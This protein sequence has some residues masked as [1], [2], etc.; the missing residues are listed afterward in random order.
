MSDAF[1]S[2]NRSAPSDSRTSLSLLGRVRAGESQAWQRLVALYRPLVHH[3][4]RR[5]GVI[6]DDAEDIVQ[7]VFAT[8]AARIDTFRHDRPGDTFRGWLCGIHRNK[9]LA[10]HRRRGQQPQASGGSA[11]FHLLE[12]VPD[13]AEESPSDVS[14]AD[15]PADDDEITALFRRAM[16]LV[17][18]EF[19][20]GT[21]AAFWGT[22][23]EGRPT[24]DLAAELG[25]SPT[26]VRMA[27]SR[28]L[29]RLRQE[30]GD[31][32]D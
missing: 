15:D 6:D 10:F 12:Q 4:C 7:E 26:A 27:K 9:I 32:A 22:A 14:V 2:S 24:R 18:T 1:P 31:L 19:A 30:V 25:V 3:W 11:L 29:R 16:A 5:S 21:W 23:V 28:V 13:S 20:S 17:Q 8:A